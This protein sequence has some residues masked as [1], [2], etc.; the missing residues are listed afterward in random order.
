MNRALPL[1]D[2]EL[3]QPGKACIVTDEGAYTYRDV[4]SRIRSAAAALSDRVTKGTRVG[5]FIDSTPNFIVYEY[6]VFYLGGI[7]APINRALKDAEVQGI[8]EHL[9]ISVVVADGPLDIG[10]SARVITVTGEIPEDDGAAAEVPLAEV[11]PEDGALLLQTSGSTGRPKGVLLTVRNLSS[12]Y[13]ASYRWLGIGKE[14]RILLTLPVFNT[15]A[16]NQGINMLAM[17]G[18]TLRLLRRFSPEG[19]AR[20][21]DDIRPTFIPFVPTMVTR[22]YQAGIRYDEPIRIG[23]GAAAS[24]ANIASDAWTVFP[25]AM[26][27]MGYGLTEATAITSVN[28]I[29]TSTDNTGDFASAG[30]IVPGQQVRIGGSGDDDRGEVLIRGAN[31]FSAYVGTSEPR[32]VDDGWLDTGDI[33]RF[34]E[35]HRLHIVDRKRELII[36]GGQNIYPSEIERALS[37]HP[38]VLEVSV[39]GAADDDLGEVPVAFVT[40]RRDAD[41]GGD[42]LVAWLTSRL[43]AFKLPA[44]VH[45]IDEFP[46]TATGKIRK[47]DLKERASA[48]RKARG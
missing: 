23:I 13:D 38:A 9:G 3:S 19:V 4:A 12:N 1:L 41:T 44:Q 10:D 2:W 11:E 29:G 25:Q 37:S 20:A 33:G 6:A 40:L 26:L 31:V 46:K 15:Y 18:A 8:V 22:L 47:L 21:L 39:V 28:H 24:P 16:L 48:A 14:D 17:T 43:A 7:V 36:R 5:L 32:P 35:N 30:V 45:L 42:G 27:Y 34:D